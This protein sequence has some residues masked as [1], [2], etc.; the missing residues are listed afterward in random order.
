MACDE[1][2]YTHAQVQDF[3]FTYYLVF[4]CGPMKNMKYFYSK[5]SA[6]HRKLKAFR[7]V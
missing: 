4:F 5:P 3:L 1:K 2:L 6:E 7:T